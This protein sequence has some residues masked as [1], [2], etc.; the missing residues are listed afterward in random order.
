MTRTYL[1]FGLIAAGGLVASPARAHNKGGDEDHMF[2][3]MDTDGDGKISAEEHAAGAKKM[4][5][6]MDTNHDGYLTKAEM[7]A[8]HRSMMHKKEK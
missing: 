7:A 4:F 5:D 1:M 6:M 2:K 8:G 3:M